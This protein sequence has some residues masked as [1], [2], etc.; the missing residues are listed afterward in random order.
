M[1]VNVDI[2][3]PHMP[4]DILS[5]DVQDIMG[6]NKIDVSGP[7]KKIRISKSGEFLT[8]DSVFDNLKDDTGC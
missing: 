3:F 8:K 6:T 7:L 2:Y 4:C 1:T 5:L